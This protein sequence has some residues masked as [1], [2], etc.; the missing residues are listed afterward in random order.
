[1]ILVDTTAIVADT[2]E[3]QSDDVPALIAALS[4][5]TSAAIATAVLTT[6]ITESYAGLAAEP[7]LA[8]ILYEIRSNLLERGISG[9]TVTTK[10]LDGSTTATTSTLDDATTPTSTTRAS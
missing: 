2:N 9:T 8:E 3:L 6:A 1:L 5:P 7:T 10:K 4:D